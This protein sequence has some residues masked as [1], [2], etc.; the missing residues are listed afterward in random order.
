MTFSNYKFTNFTFKNLK[1]SNDDKIDN[2][3]NK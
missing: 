2:P 3:N 1:V